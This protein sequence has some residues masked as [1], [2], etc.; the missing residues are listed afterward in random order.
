MDSEYRSVTNY[1]NTAGIINSFIRQIL[2]LYCLP[3]LYASAYAIVHSSQ[4]HASSPLDRRY[5]L[6]SL[7][8]LSENVPNDNLSLR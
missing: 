1:P 2:S 3:L 5:F 6:K 7:C 8:T 4:L